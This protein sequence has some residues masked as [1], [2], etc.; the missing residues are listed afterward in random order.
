MSHARDYTTRTQ[1]PGKLYRAITSLI[2]GSFLMLV[3]ACMSLGSGGTDSAAAV[4]LRTLAVPS[5]YG[6][7]QL[8]VNAASDGDTV[9]VS[10]GTY[11]ESNIDFYGKDITLKSV[12]GAAATIIDRKS[13]RLNSSHIPLSRMPSSA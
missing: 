6:S 13:T 3:F 4:Y 10:D 11:Y 1:C 7:I 2:L 8:A 12:N 5:Q 9:L